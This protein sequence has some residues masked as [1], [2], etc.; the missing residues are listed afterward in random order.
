MFFCA[1][2]AEA[3]ERKHAQA[4]SERAGFRAFFFARTL[5]TSQLGERV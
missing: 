3:K 5:R 4:A 2:E 1:S